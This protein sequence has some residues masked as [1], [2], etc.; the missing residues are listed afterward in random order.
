MQIQKILLSVAI[1]ASTI[2]A[3]G[4]NCHGSANCDTEPEQ[5]SLSTLVDLV[6]GA[7]DNRWYN[8]GEKIACMWENFFSGAF[9]AFWQG[10]NGNSGRESKL[11][12]Q[13]LSDHG[14]GLC[15]SIPYGF[16]TTNDINNGY[17]T[18]NFVTDNCLEHEGT[19][20]CP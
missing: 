12:I 18:V 7:D 5:L 14:C 19:G 10:S 2:A 3:E 6:K 17:L 20:L 8:N 15:G 16:P 13:S 4:I 9:C 1:M 11:Y